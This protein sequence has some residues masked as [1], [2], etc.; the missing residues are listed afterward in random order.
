MHQFKEN[1][2][3]EKLN[4]KRKKTTFF[5]NSTRKQKVKQT[6]WNETTNYLLYINPQ[7]QKCWDIE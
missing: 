6:Q 3:I 2:W 5:K 7:L 1:K 4:S